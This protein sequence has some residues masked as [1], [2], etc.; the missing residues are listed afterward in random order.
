ME[1]FSRVNQDLLLLMPPDAAIVVE[2]GCGSGALGELYRRVNPACRYVGLEINPEAAA[3]AAGRLSAVVTGNAEEIILDEGNVDC[4]VYGDVLEH[5]TDPWATLQRHS[6]GLKEGGQVLACIPNVQHWSVILGLLKGQWQYRAEGLLDATHLRF[7]TLDG[8]REMF[9]RAGL[10]VFEI[11]PRVF[12]HPGFQEFREAILPVLDRLGIDK[13]AF[14]SQSEAFQYIVRA[15]KGPA[16]ADRLFVQAML[17]ETKV[18]SRVRIT[19]PN[20]FLATIPGVRCQ[21]GEK[22][23]RLDLALPDENKVF[24]WQRIC[25]DNITKQQELL[26]RG[27]LILAEIDDDPLRWPSHQAGDFLT[28]RSC[29]GVQVST[30]PLAEFLRQFNPNVAVFPNQLAYLPPPRSYNDGG[31]VN[32]FFGA[33]NREED[34]QP[35]IGKLNQVIG[36][37]PEK[38]KI[39][40]VH[41]RRF[42][43]S[44]ATDCKEFLPFCP[45]PDYEAA[46]RRADIAILPLEP[47]RFNSMKSDLKFLE[48]AGHGVAALVSPTVYERSVADGETGLIYRS[49]DEF[50]EKLTALIEDAELRRKIAGKAY[51][52]VADNRLLSQHYRERYD[53]YLAMA[54]RLPELNQSLEQRVP[55]IISRMPQPK[56]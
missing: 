25:I 42:F 1:Y 14:L 47:N 33:L 37:L 16:P 3:I 12:R 9:A 4:L 30:E 22:T 41:D 35:I 50:R 23:V 8:I 31:Q 10:T 38:I 29:H 24:I 48:C 2:V 56:R 54:A 11:R 44:L 6:A 26:R 46:L 52:W 20:G 27:Y 34:W 36:S 21:A 40:V 7:F 5:M 13:N 18:C 49:P 51:L 43:E 17:G 19:E 15:V 32:I 45:Y 55:G 28:F 53:W 39:T